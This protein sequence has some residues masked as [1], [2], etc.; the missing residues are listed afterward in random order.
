M[1]L[2]IIALASIAVAGMW[3][4]LVTPT[5]AQATE[6]ATESNSRL[7]S[8]APVDQRV[9]GPYT[10]KSGFVWREAVN[11]DLVCVTPQAR[12]IAANENAAAPGRTLPTGW[13]VSGFVWR[14]SRPSDLACVPVASR[15]R[16]A[17]ENVDAVHNLADPAATPRGGLTLSIERTQRGYWLYVS[18]GG[19]SP[20]GWVSFYAVGSN[21]Q[22][23]YSL[24]HSLIANSSGAVA[25]RS[26]IGE[27]V[28][29]S[30]VLQPAT[31]VVNDRRSGIVTT[32]GTT[33]ARTC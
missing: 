23:P 5:Q 16:V 1:R 8:P 31:I 18:G 3:A 9:F 14:E 21:W 25:D 27:I 11:G 13:C 10:C 32:A 22:G 26:Y 4:S 30:S 6:K 17:R 29:N 28:C 20:N 15:D 33:P 7:A 12:Q 24:G 2:R 19:M